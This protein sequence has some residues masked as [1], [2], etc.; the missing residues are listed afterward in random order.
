MTIQIPPGTNARLVHYQKIG[1][2]LAVCEASD[3]R[4]G[5]PWIPPT[6]CVLSLRGERTAESPILGDFLRFALVEVPTAELVSYSDSLEQS[7]AKKDLEPDLT[8]FE[9]SF[10]ERN[11]FPLLV[12]LFSGLVCWLFAIALGCTASLAFILAI[13]GSGICFMCAATLVT[14]DHRI[15]TFLAA[16]DCEICRRQ[17]IDPEGSGNLQIYAT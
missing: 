16:L 4:V 3:F 8:L 14:D 17:G 11:A 10:F 13:A 12:L 9:P 7:A 1:H 6:P 15:T 2:V 5:I